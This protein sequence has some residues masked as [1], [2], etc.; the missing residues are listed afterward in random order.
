MIESRQM[1][2]A[3]KHQDAH[4]VF[5]GMAESAGLFARAGH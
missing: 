5:G 3:V 1:Q 2:R 4:F